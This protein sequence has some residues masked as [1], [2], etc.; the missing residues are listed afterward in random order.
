MEKAE[1]YLG[2][3]THTK[4]FYLYN[5]WFIP[6]IAIIY[7]FACVAGIIVGLRLVSLSFLWISLAGIFLAN[8][9]VF[10]FGVLSETKRIYGKVEVT[11]QEDGTLF[12]Y[13]D[14]GSV[15]QTKK[16]KPIQ[17]IPFHGYVLVKEASWNKYVFMT[18]EACQKLGLKIEEKKKR[19]DCCKERA[20]W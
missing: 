4:L 14:L 15:L 6:S 11:P 13:A 18:R 8:G 7:L 10:L 20:C 3:K 19:F 12:I 1:Y 9:I 5:W 17:V 16:I 2:A